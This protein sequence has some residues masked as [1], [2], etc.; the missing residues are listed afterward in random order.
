LFGY[1][2]EY[3]QE[4]DKVKFIHN[5]YKNYLLLNNESFEEWNKMITEVNKAYREV[6]IL[7][8]K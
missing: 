5:Y 1:K 6:I 8:K 4:G 7:K 3:K 2:I